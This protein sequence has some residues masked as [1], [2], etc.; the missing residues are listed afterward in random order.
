MIG[1]A[2]LTLPCAGPARLRFESS[3]LRARL[4]RGT[5][6]EVNAWIRWSS[7]QIWNRWERR[8]YS[9]VGAG[10]HR[11]ELW[12]AERPSQTV[13]VYAAVGAIFGLVVSLGEPRGTA[14]GLA[15][16]LAALSGGL[17]W[18][19]SRAHHAAVQRWVGDGRTVP[20][21]HS[22]PTHTE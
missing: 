6:R 4:V 14:V 10:P 22:G 5:S 11:W 3:G 2:A 7:Q 12:I 20:S 19:T 21:D 18:A 9:K 15:A 1:A 16:V 17:G 8:R 13:G